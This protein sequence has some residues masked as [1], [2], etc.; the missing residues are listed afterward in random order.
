MALMSIKLQLIV[1][2][3]V[4]ICVNHNLGW[5]VSQAPSKVWEKLFDQFNSSQENKNT[6]QMKT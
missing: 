1:H 2:Y 4:N 6:L 5:K 3:F